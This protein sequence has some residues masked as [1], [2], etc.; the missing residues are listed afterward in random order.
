MNCTKQDKAVLEVELRKM[1]GNK[2]EPVKYSL[3]A[4]QKIKGLRGMN[5]IDPWRKEKP[6]PAATRNGK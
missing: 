1:F 3:S 5:C 2:L 6:F 4:G